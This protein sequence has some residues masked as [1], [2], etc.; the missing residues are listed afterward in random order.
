MISQALGWV[1]R[2]AM[3]RMDSTQLRELRE[4]RAY[5]RDMEPILDNIDMLLKLTECEDEV[6]VPL[7]TS[8]FWHPDYQ[9]SAKDG[10]RRFLLSQPVPMLTPHAELHRPVQSYQ[11]MVSHIMYTASIDHRE[12]LLRRTPHEMRCL[13]DRLT[14]QIREG[15]FMHLAE[16]AT[17]PVKRAH[18]IRV[19]SG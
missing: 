12:L 7:A 6:S 2:K 14:S 13:T 8:D 3:S 16:C 11:A 10:P 15:L 4:L 17:D 5:A 1:K 19:S 9:S 18:A